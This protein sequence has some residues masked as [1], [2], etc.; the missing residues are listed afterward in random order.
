MNPYRAINC[1]LLLLWICR[2]AHTEKLND[3]EIRLRL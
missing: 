3:R 2:R 1:L